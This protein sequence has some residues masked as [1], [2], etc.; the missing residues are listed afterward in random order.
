VRGPQGPGYISPDGRF[1]IKA[2]GWDFGTIYQGFG[3]FTGGL[4][5]IN[6]GDSTAG[7]IDKTGRIQIPV[8]FNWTFGFSEGMAAVRVGDKWGY[9]NTTGTMVIQLQ[10]SNATSFVDGLAL[11]ETGT[12]WSYIDAHGSVVLGDV[13]RSK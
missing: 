3:V 6:Q 1:A 5:P 7:F 11:V 12:F 8:R 9:I 4:A 10:F 2:A 13:F